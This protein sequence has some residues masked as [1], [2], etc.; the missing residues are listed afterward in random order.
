MPE[1]RPGTDGA[2]GLPLEQKR[3]D[4]AEVSAT[5]AHCPEQAGILVRAGDDEAAVG[6][7]HI[8]CEKIVDG[9][10]VFSRQMAHASAQGQTGNPR[11]GDDARRHG[12][13]EGV[14]RMINIAPP[15]T[16]AHADMAG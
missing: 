7:H 3:S 13:A 15:A 11:R 16:G 2:D 9:Q 10:A 6:Q 1:H 12:E 8:D 4:D 5:T 14:G